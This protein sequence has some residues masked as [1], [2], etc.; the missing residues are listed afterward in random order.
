V[1]R[2]TWI[3]AVLFVIFAAVLLFRIIPQ[4][5]FWPYRATIGSH[6]V[7]SEI[8]IGPNLSTLIRSAENLQIRSSIRP[9][10]KSQSIFLTGGGL[11]WK[12][13]AMQSSGAFATT[14]PLVENIFINKASIDQNEIKTGRIVGGIRPL[15]R[16]LAHE[17]AHSLLRSHFGLTG[18]VTK[19]SWFT[20]GYCDYVADNSS[21]TAQD[22]ANLRMS[23][24]SHPALPYYKGR[25]KIE[26]L[27]EREHQTVDQI[28]ASNTKIQSE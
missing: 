9:L 28:F 25:L 17:M 3:S 19:P 12:L 21:L 5:L 6:E 7:Y 13:I 26:S 23:Q 18:M 1:K 15:D 4:I 16:V 14:I 27:I 2:S 11:R 22:V 24:S 8:P 20:E 10:V